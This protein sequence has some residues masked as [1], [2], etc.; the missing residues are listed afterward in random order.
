LTI[1]PAL[2]AVPPERQWRYRAT[3]FGIAA[4]AAILLFITTTEWLRQILI[5]PNDARRADMLVVVQEGIRRLLQGRNPYTIYHVP[6]EVTLPYGPLLWAPFAV[7]FALHADIRFVSLVGELFVPVLVAIVA[8]GC[9]LRYRF[10]IVYFWV[11]LLAV[12]SLSA[13]LRNFTPIAHTPSYW[14]LIVAF[15]WTV[16]RERWTAAALLAG[17]LIVARTTMV[18]VAPVLLI[19]V[20]HRDRPRFTRTFAVLVAATVLPY[21]PFA[22]W[23]WRA[24]WYALYGSYQSL[25]K[26]FVWTSTTW[27]RD[28]VGLTG[29]LLRI[30]AERLV[31]PAQV[32]VMLIVCAAAWRSIAR[33]RRPLPWMALALLVFCMTTLWPV[34]YIYLDVFLLLTAGALAE[35]AWL[36]QRRLTPVFA[37]ALA[38]T[39]VLVAATAYASIPRSP[40]IDIGSERDRPFLYRGFADDE[41]GDRTFT[42]VD[43]REA[44]VLVPRRSRGDA[45]IEIV[46]EPNLPGPGATQSM[47]VMLN[48]ALLDTVPLREGW[49]T[50]AID[51]P[52]RAWL[53]GVN[54]LT[55]SFS[56]AISPLEAGVG[57][58][59]RKLSARFDRVTVR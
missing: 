21:L 2:A 32:V 29:F 49:Q 18:A 44:T 33:G 10:Q 48:G 53:Y 40:E 45:R 4:V 25:M 58:D 50:V 56:S 41:K 27:A 17:L 7:P 34:G 9:A 43:G 46:C 55:L 14:P 24:L 3:A 42:W 59:T 38:A 54:E 37:G 28:S 13:D 26:G 51:A 35:T 31:E 8:V 12:F 30:H 23:D 22:I 19:A 57:A 52:S 47:S 15:A 11:T 36:R 5:F 20:W 16:Q 6:W 1:D 39:A